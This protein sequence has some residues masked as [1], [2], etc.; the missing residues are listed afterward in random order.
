[1][2]QKYCDLHIHSAYSDGERSVE[3]L[4]EY[5]AKKNLY[6]LSITDHDCVDAYFEIQDK[7]LSKKHSMQILVG[8]EFGALAQGVPI[9]MLGYGFDILPIKQYLDKFGFPQSKRDRIH[10]Q[11]F[12]NVAKM[13]GIDIDFDYDRDYK[14]AKKD[15]KFALFYFDLLKNQKF[16]DA[17]KKEDPKFVERSAAFM[18]FGLN[19]PNSIFYQKTA[20]VFAPAKNVADIIHQNGGLCFLAHPYQYGENMLDIL[21]S[22]KNTIDGVECYHYTSVD[23]EK[24]QVLFDF[25]KKNNL[26][27]SGGSDYHFVVDPKGCKD[28][29]NEFCVPQQCFDEILKKAKGKNPLV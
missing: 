12:V 2:E 15:M 11:N 1:M 14:N 9:E 3:N 6:K 26:M 22:L 23:K 24:Q 27:I 16:Y 19:N 5:A 10:C 4:L 8:C 13:L 29:L 20:Q 17:L 28:K 25:C 21:E 7:N 18:R